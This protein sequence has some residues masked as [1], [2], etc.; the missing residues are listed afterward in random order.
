VSS[1]KDQIEATIASI[2]ADGAYDGMPTYNV[3]AQR[4]NDIRAISPPH[5]TAVLSA[6]RGPK[7]S[8]RDQ[9]VLSIAAYGRLGWQEET[10]YG[11]QLWLKPRCSDIRQSSVLACGRAAYLDNSLKR[12]SAWR[13]SIACWTRDL[14]I[15]FA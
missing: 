1:L 8:Q 7:R 4:S 14:R 2:T 10:G 3:V 15:P 5:V 9:Q 13:S 6:K 12:L 11:R